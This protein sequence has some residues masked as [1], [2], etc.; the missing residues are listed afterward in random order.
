MAEVDVKDRSS[1]GGRRR[2]REARETPVAAGGVVVLGVDLDADVVRARRR[3]EGRRI[4]GGAGL[5]ERFG[6][7]AGRGVRGLVARGYC[8]VGINRT[9]SYEGSS[10]VRQP[11]AAKRPR[12]F[13]RV[14]RPGH[15][16]E[17]SK[18]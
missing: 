14:N 6:A 8:G 1:S 5:A 11:W 13:H 3:G 18:R 9:G 12:T 2:R 15:E 7:S 16:I 4:A 10:Y 17:G